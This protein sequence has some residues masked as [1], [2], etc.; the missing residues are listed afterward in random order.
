MNPRFY[1][2]GSLLKGTDVPALKG[3]R[4]DEAGGADLLSGTILETRTANLPKRVG[5]PK[6][7]GSAS[8][9]TFYSFRT[10]SDG[11]GQ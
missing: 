8:P 6:P 7:L 5:Y 10:P 11:L 3:R 1:F 9:L 2:P 4:E